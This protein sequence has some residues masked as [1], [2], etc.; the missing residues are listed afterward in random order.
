MSSQATILTEGSRAPQ[1]SLPSSTGQTIKLADYLNKSDVVLYFYPRADTPGCTIE[2]C[3]F[4][5]ALASYRKLDVPVFGISPDPP[6]DVTKFAG[7]FSLNFPLLADADHSVAEK[8]GVWQEKNRYGKVYWG[9]AR[10]TFVIGRDGRIA[11][12]FK[13]VKPEGHDQEVLMY[14]RERV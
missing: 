1:F 13:N 11:K 12:V 14:L 7:K 9:V 4:R 5:D 10:T 3:A 6:E 2:A 8:Y